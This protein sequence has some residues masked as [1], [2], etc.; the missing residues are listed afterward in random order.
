MR[1]IPKMPHRPILHPKPLIHTEK[2][3]KCG[4]K[5]SGIT[6]IFEL[7]KGVFF[8]R[9]CKDKATGEDNGPR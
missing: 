2:C 5:I 1:P 4:H 3:A 9:W 7:E 6:E 8:C